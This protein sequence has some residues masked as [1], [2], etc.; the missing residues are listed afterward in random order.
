MPVHS[1]GGV[2]L[3]PPPPMAGGIAPGGAAGPDLNRKHVR[4]TLHWDALKQQDLQALSNIGRKKTIWMEDSDEDV[5]DDYGDV[6][7]DS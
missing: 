5:D 4:V 1:A 7:A 6:D 2:P 3:P